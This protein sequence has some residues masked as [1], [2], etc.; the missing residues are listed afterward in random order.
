MRRFQKRNRSGLARERWIMAAG[1][2]IVLGALTLTGLYVRN[3]SNQSYDGYI[4]D[5]T[6]L[7]DWDRQMAQTESFPDG[8]GLQI[9]DNLMPSDDLDYDPFY[10]ETSSRGVD[11]QPA[12]TLSS[13]VIE[14]I[15]GPDPDLFIANSNAVMEG[16]TSSDLEIGELVMAAEERSGAD[17]LREETKEPVRETQGSVT[18]SPGPSPSPAESPATTAPTAPIVPAMSS[19]VQPALAFKDGDNLAWP[20]VGNVLINYSMDKSVYF[21]TLK[22]YKYNPAIIIQAK[23]GDIISAAAAGKV[24]KIYNDREIG[25]TVQIDLG[26]G[27]EI[28]YGQ[29]QNI[30]VSEGSFVSAGDIIAEV[31]AP[32]KYFSVEGTNVYFKLTKN[33][34][35]VNPLSKLS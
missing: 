6:T 26:N 35:P 24:T 33:G 14:Q 30:L 20:I 13:E 7:E 29:L 4:I 34:V 8:D 11:S 16:I 27:F 25:N 10:Q 19:V 1:S 32:T 12:A 28:T 21:P 17:D 23:E 5:L 2:V 9:I 15:G 3:I 31:A 18:S 22:Q